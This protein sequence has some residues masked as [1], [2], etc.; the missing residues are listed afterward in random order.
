MARIRMMFEIDDINITSEKKSREYEEED[1]GDIYYDRLSN[2]ID[3]SSRLL[4]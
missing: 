3:K 1:L 4:E 2:K